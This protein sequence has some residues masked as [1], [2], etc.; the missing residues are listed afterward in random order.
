MRHLQ[1]VQ[2]GQPSGPWKLVE[3]TKESG[4]WSLKCGALSLELED[5][6]HKTSLEVEKPSS[7]GEILGLGF[8]QDFQRANRLVGLSCR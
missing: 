2:R 7:V 6:E 1:V 5:T 3:I 8:W 4:V